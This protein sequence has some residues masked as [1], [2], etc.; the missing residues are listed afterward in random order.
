MLRTSVLLSEA[1]PLQPSPPGPCRTPRKVDVRLP[2]KGSSNS[3]GARPV[4]QIITMIKWI[5]TSRL[6]IKNSLCR[7]PRAQMQDTFRNWC[8]FVEHRKRIRKGRALVE[9]LGLGVSKVDWTI[10]FDFVVEC[11][12]PSSRIANASAKVPDEA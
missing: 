12:A 6:S 7:T 2:G 1:L 3:H 11:S 5:Q 10:T 4:H 9:R 8:N